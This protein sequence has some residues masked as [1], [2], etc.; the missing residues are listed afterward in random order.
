MGFLVSKKH[1]LQPFYFHVCLRPITRR[2]VVS[3]STNAPLNSPYHLK[4]SPLVVCWFLSDLLVWAS[5]Y[6]FWTRCSLQNKLLRLPRLLCRGDTQENK[7]QDSLST[8]ALQRNNVR[9]AYVRKLVYQLRT[10]P[11]E[12]IT[13][14]TGSL[15]TTYS[16]YKQT[17]K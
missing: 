4:I 10:K 16:Q 1:C 11:P 2:N 5:R 13:S 14:I 9:T 15:Q 3:L 12:Q 6:G 7:T 8:N 17:R